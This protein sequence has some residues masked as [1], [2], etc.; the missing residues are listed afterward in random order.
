MFKLA[1]LI[2]STV[3]VA[4]VHSDLIGYNRLGN[5]VRLHKQGRRT[6]RPDGFRRQ[7]AMW[8]A[9][10]D[11]TIHSLNNG[12][13]QIPNRRKPHRQHRLSHYIHHMKQIN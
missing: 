2:I 9:V 12:H 1:V 10:N 7:I 4:S 11:E 13:F 5:N 8:M 3:L 6:R